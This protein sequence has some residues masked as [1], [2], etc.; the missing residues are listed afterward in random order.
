[1]RLG[2]FDANVS[3]DT[4]A[5]RMFGPHVRMRFRHRYE[6]DPRYVERLNEEGLIFS[7]KSPR[8]EIYNILEL[9]ESMHPYFIGT[10]AH[11]ELTSR[12]LHP[13]PMFVGLVHAALKR[14][15]PD[16]TDE[17]DYSQLA[18]TPA[19][20]NQSESMAPSSH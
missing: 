12:P 16:Y 4:L 7:G 11:P 15:Y 19:D 17:L 14:A 18:L 10:Q 20:D 13:H 6:V 9:P 1:M 8:A 5:Y 3:E 2:G